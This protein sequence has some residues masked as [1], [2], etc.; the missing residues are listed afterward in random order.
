LVDSPLQL[1]RSVL[2]GASRTLLSRGSRF[3]PA[4]FRVELAAGPAI[5]KDVG[6]VPSST[7]WLARWLMNR[8]RHILARLRG[9]EGF[10]TVQAEL[11]RDAFLIEMLPGVPLDADAFLAQPREL[12]D[13]FK[14]RIAQMHARGVVHLDL[15]Q[16][17]NIL[18]AGPTDP[19]IVDFGAAWAPGPIGRLLF[20]GLLRWVDRQAA[21]KYLARYAPQQMRADEART[22]LRSLRLRRL[23]FVSPHRDSGQR[24]ACRKILAAE[25][26]DRAK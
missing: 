6:E 4:V 19:R 22:L 23:W 16:R 26:N 25:R 1:P 12:I 13:C 10:P 5:L 2:E 15:K 11:G 21:L 14:D 18:I 9:V 24:E 8:E 3:K 17:Q 20:G 7:R